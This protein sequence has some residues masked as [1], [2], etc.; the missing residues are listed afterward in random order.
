M[1]DKSNT[2]GGIMKSIGRL[3]GSDMY[4]V[5]NA[6]F[7]AKIS[8]GSIDGS[9]RE[10]K[11]FLLNSSTGDHEYRSNIPVGWALWKDYATTFDL[12]SKC[13]QIG[14]CYFHA[15]SWLAKVF[16]EFGHAWDLANPNSEQLRACALRNGNLGG[17][18]LTLSPEDALELLRE[19]RV[20]WDW[21]MKELETV[22]LREINNEKLQKLILDE[23]IDSYL[24]VIVSEDSEWGIKCV[25]T[26]DA[27][28]FNR[29][30]ITPLQEAFRQRIIE[31]QNAWT[32]EHFPTANYDLA[33][34]IERNGK[35]LLQ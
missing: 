11:S 22:G 32:R 19:E 8:L 34:V 35:A 10:I 24:R 16:H 13:V 3:E 27:D 29:Q 15:F 26:L 21:C 9:G 31:E 17:V 23:C 20:A 6:G 2:I 14:E 33:R 5:E 4:I 30:K 7:C 25:K 18:N 12:Q 28:P 1:S